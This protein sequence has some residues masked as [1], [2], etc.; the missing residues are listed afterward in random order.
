MRR[1]ICSEHERANPARLKLRVLPVLT[2]R[3]GLGC[4]YPERNETLSL[5]AIA[6]PL[7]RLEPHPLK[8]SPAPLYY[9][10]GKHGCGHCV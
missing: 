2:P 5:W 8:L 9:G 4:S 10:K 1:S 6:L 7:A 3:G